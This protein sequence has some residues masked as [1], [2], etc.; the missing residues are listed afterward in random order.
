MKH[1][2]W[3]LSVLPLL[4]FVIAGCVIIADGDSTLTIR[5]DSSTSLRDVRLAERGDRWGPNLLPYPLQP[6]AEVVLD[7][8]DCG[9]YDVL[10]EDG[11][12]ASCVLYGV[13]LCFDDHVWVIDDRT[14]AWCEL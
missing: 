10:V 11:P 14:L 12:G 2:P 5:N 4:A 8:I 13:H 9:Y 6:G 1:P 7:G 3:K